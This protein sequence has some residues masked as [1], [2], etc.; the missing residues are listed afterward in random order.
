M[1][2]WNRLPP[3]NSCEPTSKS[4]RLPRISSS[5]PSSCRLAFKAYRKSRWGASGGKSDGEQL[6][7]L[8]NGKVRFAAVYGNGA[9]LGFTPQEVRRMSMWQFMAAVD[10]YVKANSTDDGGLSQK[11]KDELWEWVSEGRVALLAKYG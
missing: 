4:A 6:D 3:R 10:G 2:A 8:P 1:E 5:P 11:E 9:A 7:S